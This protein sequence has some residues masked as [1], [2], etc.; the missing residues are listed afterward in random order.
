MDP[1]MSYAV[2]IKLMLTGWETR[3]DLV[4]EHKILLMV[5]IHKLLYIRREA[6]MPQYGGIDFQVQG[7]ARMT[8]GLVIYKD[9]WL[10]KCSLFWEA[11]IYFY[12][13]IA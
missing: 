11:I 1:C 9:I 8:A 6:C 5:K 12:I 3:T 2:I 10:L 7:W 13:A 4:M